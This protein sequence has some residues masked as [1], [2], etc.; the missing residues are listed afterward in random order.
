MRHLIDFDQMSLSEWD[1]LYR[2]AEDIMNRP[3]AYQDSC[4]GKLVATLF[5]EPSTRTQFS[6]QAA[7][8]RLGAQ[9]IGFSGAGGSSVAKGEN[10]KDTIRTVAGYVDAIVMRHPSEGA[11]LAA[12]LASEVPVVNA[13]DGGHL[14]PTQTLTDL[15]TLMKERGTLEGLTVGICGDLKNGRTVHSLLKALVRFPN[16]RFVLISTANLRIPAYVREVLEAAGAPFEEVTDLAAVMDRLDVL[17]MTRIQRERFESEEAYKKEAGIYV[18]DKRK[19][20][21]GK[22]DLLVLHPL[23]KVDEITH[24]ADADPRCRY[25]EQTRYG[26][27]IRMALLHTLM[28]Q[29]RAAPAEAGGEVGGSCRNPRCITATEDWLDA[30][31][32]G[33]RCLY[34]EKELAL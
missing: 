7:A 6:F 20:D 3:A 10:L 31:R 4:R 33:D 14:H 13:G 19:L 1:S 25:F 30:R 27:F 18:L 2:L 5:Y 23:P 21:L 29:G 16:N 9:V 34:C 26:M 28:L 32:I 24:E 22:R 8:M 11:A 12:S 17:Y 15:T